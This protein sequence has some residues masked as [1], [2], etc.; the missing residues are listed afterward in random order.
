MDANKAE[1]KKLNTQV[2]LGVCKEI[3]MRLHGVTGSADA[4]TKQGQLLDMIALTPGTVFDAS[5]LFIAER[6]DVHHPS[7]WQGAVLGLAL[8]ALS[9]DAEK[10]AQIRT[11]CDRADAAMKAD[12]LAASARKGSPD[13]K[14]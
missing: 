2:N 14:V 3:A 5:V 11:M 9:T 6:K 10:V 4:T 7:L 1:F 13:G 8:A 12:Q